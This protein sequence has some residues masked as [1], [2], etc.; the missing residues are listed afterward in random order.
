[1]SYGTDT[2]LKQRLRPGSSGNKL[3]LAKAGIEYAY[4]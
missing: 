1:M 2:D 3:H 4:G